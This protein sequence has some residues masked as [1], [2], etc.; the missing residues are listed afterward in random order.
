MASTAKEKGDFKRELPPP[1]TYI[2]RCVQFIDMGHQFDERWD[3]WINKI[4]LGWELPT[5]ER[6]GYTLPDGTERPAAPH[7]IWCQYTLSLNS[8][9]HL[10]KALKSWRGRDFT[11][12]ELEGFSMSNVIDKCCMLNIVHSEDGQWANVSAVMKLPSGT[13]VPPRHHDIVFFDV[14][15]PDMTLFETFSE[16]L[17][18]KIKKSREWSEKDQSGYEEPADGA[19]PAIDDDDVPF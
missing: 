5:T 12:E 13:Q 9:S 17:Q 11:Q 1:D 2:A 3:K 4:L 10:R 6:S 19:P 14:D 7:I 18:N 8:N 15:T 16:N